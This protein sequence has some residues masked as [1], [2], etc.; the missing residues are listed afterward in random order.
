M[1]HAKWKSGLFAAQEG[2]PPD[3]VARSRTAATRRHVMSYPAM[4]I[5]RG[6]VMNNILRVVA[7]CLLLGGCATS[8][9]LVG[10]QRPEIDPGLVRIYI[11][12]PTQFEKVAILETSS[13]GS[14]ALTN[15]Q[16]TNKVIERLKEEAASLGANGV[17]IQGIGS[18][19]RGSVVNSFATANV[20][21]SRGSYTGYGSG[22]AVAAPVMVKEGTALAIYVPDAM[23]Y[24]A[25]MSTVAPPQPD[26]AKIAPGP[27]P[28]PAPM[29]QPSSP[30]PA[31]SQAPSSTPCNACAGLL[32]S[33]GR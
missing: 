6:T 9:V 3:P 7:F 16:K 14:F 2:T 23:A 17:L 8:H 26:P 24:S 33:Y 30:Q 22:F 27:D 20:Y 25:P 12:P 18:V 31:P 32:N 19:Q 15:Q 21:G 1:F 29:R 13:E 11:D 28:Q 4:G 10:T 5:C